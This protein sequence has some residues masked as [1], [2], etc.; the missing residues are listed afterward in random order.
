VKVQMIFSLFLFLILEKI[1]KICFLKKVNQLK[2]L[3]KNQL[4]NKDWRQSFQLL[5]AHL[6]KVVIVFN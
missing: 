4:D 6:L 2:K 5:L 3:L 1:L